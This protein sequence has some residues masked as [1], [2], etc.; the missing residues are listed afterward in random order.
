MMMCLSDSALCS[1]FRCRQIPLSIF[2]PAPALTHVSTS[3]I[4]DDGV[5]ARRDLWAYEPERLEPLPNAATKE[6][7]CM[8]ASDSDLGRRAAI[9]TL[10]HA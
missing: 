8:T 10:R 5:I 9:S 7:R 2:F 3:R 1:L 4:E 6:P